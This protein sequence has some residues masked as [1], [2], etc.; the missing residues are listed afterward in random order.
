MKCAIVL[1]V[2]NCGPAHD[3]SCEIRRLT[4]L[5][6]LNADRIRTFGQGR[7][8]Q[9]DCWPIRQHLHSDTPAFFLSF[10]P[11]PFRLSVPPCPWPS[12]YRRRPSHPSE[13]AR[14]AI[15]SQTTKQTASAIVFARTTFP[16]L[17]VCPTTSS[18]AP[19]IASE[20]LLRSH[21]CSSKAPAFVRLCLHV[22]GYLFVWFCYA[23]SRFFQR[24]R[25]IPTSL[26]E[27]W[28]S[29]SS[30][31]YIL[32]PEIRQAITSTDNA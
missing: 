20:A 21:R 23:A 31:Q 11:P 28:N 4:S 6:L 3:Q 17:E 22:H 10:S 7:P 19:S 9:K 32:Q 30:L 18:L 2:T 1:V 5:R 13:T 16:A 15:A 14:H 27:S 25:Y 8:K 12:S 26:V 24:H 29:I